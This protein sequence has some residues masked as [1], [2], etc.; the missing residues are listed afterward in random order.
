MVKKKETVYEILSEAFEELKRLQ[1]TIE[2]IQEYADSVENDYGVVT[3]SKHDGKGATYFLR[4]HDTTKQKFGGRVH[5]DVGYVDEKYIDQR[6]INDT[7]HLMLDKN[8]SWDF[9]NF[10]KNRRGNIETNE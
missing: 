6:D 8:Y 10:I 5:I 1:P 7:T 3:Y 9:V 4:L 2:E